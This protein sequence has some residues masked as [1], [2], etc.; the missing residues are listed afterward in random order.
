MRTYDYFDC[1]R[2]WSSCH[3]NRRGELQEMLIQLRG[4]D[5]PTFTKKVITRLRYIQED[6]SEDQDIRDL[7]KE[8]LSA[9][10]VGKQ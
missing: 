5:K 6:R 3:H 4:K 9:A 8:T 7:A 10:G 1:P 2:L